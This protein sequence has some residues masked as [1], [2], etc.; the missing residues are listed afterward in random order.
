MAKKIVLFALLAAFLALPALAELDY[1]V[2]RPSK[3]ARVSEP[4]QQDNELDEIIWTE[5]FE[6]DIAW[7]FEPVGLNILWQGS[8]WEALNDNNWRAYDPEIGTNGGYDNHWLQWMITPE[9]DLSIHEDAELSFSFRMMTEDPGGEPAGYDGWDGGNVMVSTDDGLTFTAIEPTEGPAY[10][11]TSSYAFGVEWEMGEDIPQWGGTALFDEWSGVTFDLIDYINEPSVRI[12]FVFCSDPGYGTAEEDGLTGYQVDDIFVVA[13]GGGTTLFADD[14]DGNNVGGEFVFASGTGGEALESWEILENETAPSPTHVLGIADLPTNFLHYYNYQE[15]IDLTAL[16]N[17]TT[18]LDVM[19]FG[20]W[21]HPGEFPAEPQ[22]TV[23]IQVEGDPAW[24]Y[25]SNPW[26]D[27]DGSNFVYTGGDMVDWGWFSE[28]FANPWDLTPYHGEIITIRFE[29]EVPSA[30]FDEGDKFAFFDDVKIENSFFEHDL[31]VRP[32]FIPFPTTVGHE[33]PATVTYYNNGVNEETAGAFAWTFGG[34]PNI[35][36]FQALMPDEEVTFNLDPDP[37]D[38]IDYWVP[39]EVGVVGMQAQLQLNNDNNADNN[40]TALNE[41]NVQPAGFYELGYDD[42]AAFYVTSRFGIGEGPI[43]HFVI[44]ED[45]EG[46]LL[47]ESISFQWNG[48]IEDDYNVD[49]HIFAG[50]E[51]PG[52]ELYVGTH[53]V[54]ID[55]VSPNWLSVDVTESNIVN[56]TDYWVWAEMTDLGPDDEA[57]PQILLSEEQLYGAENHFGYDGSTVTT[58]GADWL[59]RSVVYTLDGVVELGSE[60]PSTYALHEAYP[61]PFNPTTTLSFDLAKAGQVSLTVFNVVG[62]QVATL[63]NERMTAGSY[64]TTLDA[65]SM[66][67]GVYFVRMQA[68]GFN[69]VQKVMLLK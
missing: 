69:A 2:V 21:V 5:D 7:E 43:T 22:W 32:L 48:A 26:G 31:G 59:I 11:V 64:S 55:N 27:P 6:G 41:I 16:N 28:T 20:Q 68:D 33:V 46:D 45:I 39:D 35:I 60:A 42:R 37:D 30:D 12:A 49:L 63:V 18:M 29:F 61:N 62:Q 15:T 13:D 38:G 65:S 4:V 36:P 52:E 8:D 19:V 58:E 54:T 53:A 17:G 66:T 14:A 44:P 50:G 25:A 23:K 40:M 57:F 10:N 3:N 34:S 67:S 47:I 51:T 9:L 56:P 1:T 24:Y